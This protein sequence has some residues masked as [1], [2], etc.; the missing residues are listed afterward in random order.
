M[1]PIAK[2]SGFTIGEADGIGSANLNLI[3][4]SSTDQSDT[5]QSR[6]FQVTA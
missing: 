2:L 5:S 3:K 6:L 1:L 4:R